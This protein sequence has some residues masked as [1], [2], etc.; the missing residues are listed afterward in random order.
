MAIFYIIN[1]IVASETIEGGKS[2][3][4]TRYIKLTVNR[5]V[6]LLTYKVV[7]IKLQKDFDSLVRLVFRWASMHANSVSCHTMIKFVTR[8]QLLSVVTA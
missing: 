2:F 4:E 8:V 6:K 5:F 1:G 7:E 3:E